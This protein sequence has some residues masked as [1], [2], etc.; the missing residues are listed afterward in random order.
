MAADSKDKLVSS[1]KHALVTQGYHAAGLSALLAGTELPKGS[2]YHHFPRGK[3]ELAAA[4]IRSLTVDFEASFATH[5]AEA[6]DPLAA[7]RLWVSGAL[8]R[9]EKSQFSAGC[10]FATV[11]LEVASVEPEIGKAL[12]DAFAVLRACIATALEGAG[13]ANP[14]GL[15]ALVV[16]T[17][18]GALLQARAMQ[19]TSVIEGAMNTLCDLLAT[20]KNSV[21]RDAGRPRSAKKL[22]RDKKGASRA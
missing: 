15:A 9:L 8:R 14:G 10:P 6:P 17:Y 11:T 2:L 13:Y 16:S 4:A 22:S 1:M 18:E 5:F 19:S 21:Q 7:I 3:S 20:Q 12:D